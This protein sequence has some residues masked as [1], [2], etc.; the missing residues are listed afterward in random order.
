M[1][2]L[3]LRQIPA[4]VENE[5]RQLAAQNGA[6]LNQTAIAVLQKGLGLAPPARRRDLS[7]LAGKWTAAEA[8]EF[9]DNV[10]VFEQIDEEL[11]R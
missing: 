10:Q 1:K 2:Q 8:D 11:W 9:D 4:E 6:S 3:T 7:H 5:L